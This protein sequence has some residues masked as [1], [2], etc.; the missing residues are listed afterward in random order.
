MQDP[1]H[2]LARQIPDLREVTVPVAKIQP[3]VEAWT[4]KG[5]SPAYHDRMK[6]RLKREWPRLHK[7][8]TLM[9]DGDVDEWA[10]MEANHVLVVLNEVSDQLTARVGEI[11]D[12]LNVMQ[13]GGHIS[14]VQ[15]T[16]LYNKVAALLPPVRDED[17]DPDANHG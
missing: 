5:T 7:A 11:L 14:S 8:L 10:A 3:V 9:V 13:A 1:M 2:K 6:S 15:Y 4:K 16:F 12:D 17:G